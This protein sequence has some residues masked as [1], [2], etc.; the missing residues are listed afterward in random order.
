LAEDESPIQYIVNHI[1]VP[2]LWTGPKVTSHHR[3]I[4]N[5]KPL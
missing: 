1:Q 4:C 2:R 3:W 5:D